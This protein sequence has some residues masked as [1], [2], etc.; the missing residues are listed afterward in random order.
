[1]PKAPKGGAAVCLFNNTKKVAKIK[2]KARGISIWCWKRV[3]CKY[4]NLK[5]QLISPYYW[6]IWQPGINTADIKQKAATLN[7]QQV[8]N[9]IHVYRSRPKGNYSVDARL[10]KVKCYLRDLL[11]ANI[12]EELVF[13][14]VYLPTAQYKKATQ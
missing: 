14:Q 5:N 3:N 12:F 2:D 4:H 1:M 10:V 13:S 11:G 9:G 6:Y 7:Q 8:S